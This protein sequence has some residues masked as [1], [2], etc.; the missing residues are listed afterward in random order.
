MDLTSFHYYLII[1]N[2]IGCILF[3]IDQLLYRFTAKGEI[4]KLVT[5][6]CILGG[7][8]G[9]LIPK[10]L[11]QREISKKTESILRSTV[12]LYSIIPIQIILYI[13]IRKGWVTKIIN[14]ICIYFDNHQ[15]L[16]YYLIIINSITFIAFG[17]DKLYAIKNKTRIRIITLLGFSFIGGAVGGYLGM[18][19]FNHKT[20]KDYFY[21]GLPTMIVM[22]IIV[23]TY[24][25]FMK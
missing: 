14:T 15:L 7:S 2:V 5:I 21:I 3:L 8:I 24:L 22:H 20:R 18:E 4:D 17:L 16:M 23:L 13:M 25:I 9:I 10:L 19:I 6:S 12:F 1:I 11:L